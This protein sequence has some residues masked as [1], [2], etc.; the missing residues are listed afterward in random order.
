MGY[1]HGINDLAAVFLNLL[2]V[3]VLFWLCKLRLLINL[4]SIFFIRRVLD[5]KSLGKASSLTWSAVVEGIVEG[6]ARIPSI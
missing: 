1:N 6:L 3:E 2:N 5:V 4:K